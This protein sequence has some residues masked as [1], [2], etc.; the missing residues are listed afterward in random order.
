MDSR[1][2]LK[3]KCLIQLTSLQIGKKKRVSRGGSERERGEKIS[4]QI[5][6]W[7]LH[8]GLVAKVLLLHRLGSHMGIS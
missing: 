4:K 5:G 8:Y 6:Y 3:S 2:Q 7:A 1:I